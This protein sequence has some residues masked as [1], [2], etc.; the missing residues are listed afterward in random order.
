MVMATVSSRWMSW[1]HILTGDQVIAICA[2]HLKQRGQLLNNTVVT[3]VMSN[4]GLHKALK[5]MGIK[6]ITSQVGD[7]HVM[8]DM[9]ARD[10]VLGGEDSGHI[11]FHDVHT[12]GGWHAGGLAA[13]RSRFGFPKTAVGACR[14]HGYIPTSVDQCGCHIQARPGYSA[15]NRDVIRSVE[16]ALAGQ[17]RVLVRYSGTQSKCRVMVEGPTE[18]LTQGLLPSDRRCRHRLPGNVSADPAVPSLSTHRR[19]LNNPLLSFNSTSA[20]ISRWYQSGALASH[21]MVIPTD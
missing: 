17:G 7:R 16:T 18:K 20:F 14:S 10:A 3:T 8:R 11:I 2:K 21:A 6:L 1:G 4:M 9:L 15:E 19:H 13:Y 5:G 12:T